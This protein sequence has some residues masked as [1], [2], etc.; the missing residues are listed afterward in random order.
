MVRHS[1]VEFQGTHK[2]LWTM[3][4]TETFVADRGIRK[5]KCHPSG[6]WLTQ[7]FVW[8]AARFK[9]CNQ[10]VSSSLNDSLAI[11]PAMPDR[12]VNKFSDHIAFFYVIT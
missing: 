3:I 10:K 11:I 4:E 7:S 5:P 9:L 6:H 8:E 12:E 1:K 2:Q